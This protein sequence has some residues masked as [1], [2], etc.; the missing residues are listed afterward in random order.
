MAYQ[1]KELWQQRRASLDEKA[2][3]TYTRC[4]LVV[5]DNELH[6]QAT[7]IAAFIAEYGINI[8]A[9]YVTPAENDMGALCK[10]IDPQQRSESRWEWEV[11]VEYTSAYDTDDPPTETSPL[12]RPAKVRYGSSRIREPYEVDTENYYVC[13]S[14][15]DQFDPPAERDASASTITITKNKAT[16]DAITEWGYRN[17]L[18]DAD[19]SIED[20]TFATGTL[21][22]GDV[23][24]EPRTE[25]EVDFFEITYVVEYRP[26]GWSDSFIDKGRRGMDPLTGEY[27]AFTLAGNNRPVET[28]VLMNGNGDRLANPETDAVVTLDFKPYHSIDFSSVGML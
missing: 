5:T 8:G 6:G 3:R 28:D 17:K 18:N 26:Q 20:S 25:N 1:F 27:F 13:N 4:F 24:A 10:R 23:S 12:D 19:F 9:P 7:V 16:F 21:K 14:A 22:I 2:N 15:W 11:T